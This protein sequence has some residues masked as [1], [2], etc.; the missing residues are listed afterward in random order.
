MGSRRGLAIRECPGVARILQHLTDSSTARQTPDHLLSGG[1][2][3][4][5]W[6]EDS[7]FPEPNSRLPGAPQLLKF[8]EYADNRLLNL[9]IRRLLNLPFFGPDESNRHLP[10]RK[11]APHLLL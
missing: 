11:A 8:P 2:W 1:S 6:H 7:F 10:Q 4:R 3:F 5:F 9:A